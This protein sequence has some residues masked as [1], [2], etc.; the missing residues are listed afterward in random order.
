MKSRSHGTARNPSR[1]WIARGHRPLWVALH[2]AAVTAPSVLASV[3][4]A[5]GDCCVCEGSTSNFCGAITSSNVC[6]P[7]CIS[8]C[9]GFGGTM[10]ACCTGVADCSGG[11][12]DSCLADANL[13]FQTATGSGFCDGTCTAPTATPTSTPTLTPTATPTPQPNGSSCADP[14]QCASTFCVDGVCCDTA[15]TAPGEQC[16]LAG[17]IGTCASTAAPAPA[18]TPWGLL[19]AA[20]LLISVAGFA[21]RHRMRGR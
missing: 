19:V 7:A 14:A 6:G 12:A 16:N 11:S 21:L 17:Q 20:V 3:P 8:V 10:R 15:C 5:Q 2:V 4:V 13:C 18:L 1:C 9:E